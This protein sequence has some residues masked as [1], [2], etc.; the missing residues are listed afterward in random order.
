MMFRM[1]VFCVAYL[2]FCFTNKIGIT[3]EV[4]NNSSTDEIFTLEEQL[5]LFPFA[6]T[7]GAVIQIDAKNYN[8]LRSSAKQMN[9]SMCQVGKPVGKRISIKTENNN[10]ILDKCITDLERAWSQTSYHIKAMRDN[11]DDALAEYD[12]I[13]DTD[14]K[15]LFTSDTFQMSQP[16]N[17]I[18][19]FF[20]AKTKGCDS[21]GARY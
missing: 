3:W 14:H 8:L 1:E 2:N 6:E 18:F 19:N 5:K 17:S 13:S 16:K 15:G 20:K 4:A 10:V 11:K 21:E 7:I 9:I 12:L